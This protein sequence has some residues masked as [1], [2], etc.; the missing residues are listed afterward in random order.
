[1]QSNLTFINFD[2]NFIDNVSNPFNTTFI[3]T[4]PLKKVKNIYLKSVELPVGITNIRNNFDTINFQYSIVGRPTVSFSITLPHKNY[5]INDLISY[6]NSGI[7]AQY[8]PYL[9]QGGKAIPQFSVNTNNTINVSNSD[10]T[11]QFNFTST[12][13]LKQ[14]LGFTTSFLPGTSNTAM[15]VNSDKVYNLNLDNYLS[16]Y[17]AN[18]PHK[19]VGLGNQLMTFKIP[20]NATNGSIY[21]EA[22]NISFCQYSL[23]TDKNFILNKLQI[24]VYDQFNYLLDNNGF[25]W[26]FTLAFEFYTD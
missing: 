12:N 23:I 25:D 13:L 21:Y 3:L 2:T 5:A 20:F 9:P 1:M 10:S 14:I 24:Q 16:F 15:S 7:K 19:S 4:E 11:V 8:Y 6:I 17:C 22:E 26:S 18:V